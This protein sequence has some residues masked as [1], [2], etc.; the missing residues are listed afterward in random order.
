M[1]KQYFRKP[2]RIKKKKPFFKNK[3]FW[4]AILILIA[5]GGLSYFLIFSSFFDVKEI[6]ISGNE[7]IS[8][9]TIDN[10]VQG[11][12]QQDFKFFKNKNINLLAL[13]EIDKALLENF[14]EIV[15]VTSEKEL[16]NTLRIE[17][18][19]RK[20]TAIFK[21]NNNWFFADKEGIIFQQIN[22]E[23][24]TQTAEQM[25]IVRNSLLTKD[26]KLGER[27]AEKETISQ[28]LE[29][30]SKMREELKI[31]LK[32]MAI[33]SDDRLNVKTSEGWEAYF[34]LKADLNWQFI[35][36]KTV[37]EKKVLPEKRGNIIY[38]D[39]RFENVYIY[40]E[41]YNEL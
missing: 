29:L 19:E 1:K 38:I 17:I 24:A 8:R 12:I 25:T 31:P 7:K 37:L 11:K 26:L 22:E 14:P 35:K 3:F 27:I 6:K 5:I 28:I 21:Q 39:L 2:H 41:T 33:V 40:P 20:P 32:E 9:E 36:L 30:E 4:L 34:N 15:K 10:L 16:P 13:S 23:L 18:E